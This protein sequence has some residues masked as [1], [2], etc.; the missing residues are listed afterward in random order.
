MPVFLCQV[1]IISGNKQ[2]PLRNDYRSSYLTV[3]LSLISWPVFPYVR[4]TC[5]T[6]Q[7]L[8]WLSNKMKAVFWILF[9]ALFL[10]MRQPGFSVVVVV[11]FIN[12]FKSSLHIL[13]E[14]WILW[15]F[16]L[17]RRQSRSRF[18][19]HSLFHLLCLFHFPCVQ[20]L[21]S[22]PL[23]QC[24]GLGQRFIYLIIFLKRMSI[25][26]TFSERVS[27]NT[28]LLTYLYL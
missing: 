4:D 27:C 20:L 3:L 13:D 9:L 24:E 6:F 10:W 8:L 26:P 22:F 23:M 2:L 28:S 14:C 7:A 1:K 11:L 5:E 16:Q 19:L 18:L 12:N 21:L 25:M 17:V 15:P